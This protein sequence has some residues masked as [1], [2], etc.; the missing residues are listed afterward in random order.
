MNTDYARI[1]PYFRSLF[2]L[3]TTIVPRN[4]DIVPRNTEMSVFMVCG[5]CSWSTGSVFMVQWSV[6]MVIMAVFIIT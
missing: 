1:R 6:F 2:G 5:L 4:T 3:C